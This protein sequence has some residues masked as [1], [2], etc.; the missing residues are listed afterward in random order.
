MIQQKKEK[1]LQLMGIPF[2]ADKIYETYDE[3]KEELDRGFEES[4]DLSFK[5]LSSTFLTR[6]TLDVKLD[7]LIEDGLEKYKWEKDTYF[8]KL[9]VIFPESEEPTDLYLM[10][11]QDQEGYWKIYGL[12]PESSQPE[13]E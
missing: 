6:E 8:V 5:I 10:L 4:E 7:S 12:L 3:I 2:V 11:R 1:V 9:K 13:G